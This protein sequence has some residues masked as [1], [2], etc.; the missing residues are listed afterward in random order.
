MLKVGGGLTGGVVTIRRKARATT[1]A[2]I[3]A[4]DTITRRILA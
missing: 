4:I 2:Q 3:G 1:E